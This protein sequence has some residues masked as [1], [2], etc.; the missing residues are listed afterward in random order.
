MSVADLAHVDAG[1][2]QRQTPYL[3]RL[4]LAVFV[5]HLVTATHIVIIVSQSWN[6]VNPV[7]MWVRSSVPDWG[8]ANWTQPDSVVKHILH[9]NMYL[10]IFVRQ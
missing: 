2:F 7:P 3:Q 5:A 8:R 4:N 10:G 9:I 1:V 6:R